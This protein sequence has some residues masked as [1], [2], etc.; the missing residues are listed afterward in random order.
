MVDIHWVTRLADKYAEKVA[1]I[2]LGGVLKQRGEHMNWLH[3]LAQSQSPEE[4]MSRLVEAGRVNLPESFKSA[5]QAVM[6]TGKMPEVVTEGL[7]REL[8]EALEK[9]NELYLKVLNEFGV[10][11]SD[12]RTRREKRERYEAEKMIVAKGV[13]ASI[14]TGEEAKVAAEQA[15]VAEEEARRLA[16]EE[17]RRLAEEETERQRAEAVAEAIRVA[18]TAG[19]E[20]GRNQAAIEAATAGLKAEFGADLPAGMETPQEDQSVEAWQQEVRSAMI[21]NLKRE[22]EE[23]GGKLTAGRTTG[24]SEAEL[25]TAAE[26]LVQS[27]TRA[28]R[29]T[30][31]RDHAAGV[32]ESALG[33][34]PEGEDKKHDKEVADRQKE[35]LSFFEGKLDPQT[36]VNRLLRKLGGAV[37]KTPEELAETGRQIVDAEM[38]QIDRMKAAGATPGEVEQRREKLRA[39]NAALESAGILGVGAGS[40]LDAGFQLA[41]QTMFGGK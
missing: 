13:A 20:A 24:G 8:A 22:V 19:E 31:A 39:L 32:L 16:G 6:E 12:Q 38:R 25:R 3:E 1:R 17:A 14:K 10:E 27:L 18:K 40:L 4:M 29:V 7:P 33:T 34:K 41:V 5:A 28:G 11:T 15:K 21:E 36:L 2:G 26:G 23:A 30:E 9:R 35:I 37:A